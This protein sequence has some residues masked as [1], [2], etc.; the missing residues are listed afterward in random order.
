VKIVVNHLARVRAGSIDVGGIESRSRSHV[1]PVLSGDLPMDLLRRAGGPFD[2]A[3]VV[4]LGAARLVDQ[5]P[6]TETYLFER[7]GARCLGDC[8]AG[9]FWRLLQSC[10]VSSLREIT[11]AD[12]EL[13]R[14]GNCAAPVAA[15]SHSFGCLL[16]AMPPTLFVDTLGK[17]RLRMFDGVF[18]VSPPVT[19]LRCYE[20][21]HKSIR[22]QVVESVKA[23][24]ASGVPAVLSVGLSRPFQAPGD[25]M[26]RHW[27]QVNGIH[28]EDAPTW[29]GG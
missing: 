14:T 17:L 25:T 5:A 6:G 15:G 12:L 20:A 22:T 9:A 29:R 8:D 21:D 13:Q 3:A 24:L 2:I 27:L 10:A 11:G 1:R 18:L 7:S 28:L 23:R 19:D 16:P 26:Q 4:D